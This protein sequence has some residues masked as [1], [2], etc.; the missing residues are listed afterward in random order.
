MILGEDLL[1]DALDVV[2]E[3]AG[4]N[5]AVMVLQIE[6]AAVETL[7]LV[8]SA[9]CVPEFEGEHAALDFVTT[10]CA[11]SDVMSLE[12]ARRGSVIV[13]I[14]LD[15]VLA[16]PEGR[17][18]VVDE[19]R[20]APDVDTAPLIDGVLW[21]GL[22]DPTKV[23]P[24]LSAL[25]GQGET[26][27]ARLAMKLTWCSYH[28][29]T[30]MQDPVGQ[31]PGHME[32]Q[33]FLRRA[34]EACRSNGQ[35]LAVVL[36]SPDDFTMVNHRHGRE[37]GDAVV[38]EIA[39]E[40]GGCVRLTD[41][42][43]RY[44]GA[45]FALVLPGTDMD[46][47]RAAIDKIRT[48]LGAHGYVDGT[49]SLTFSVGAGVAS[50][51]DL[52]RPGIATDILQRADGGLNTAK[53]S[54]GARALV[55]SLDEDDSGLPVDPLGAV[56]AADTEKDYRN[57][58]LL[59]E[60]V[61][62]VSASPEPEAMAGAFVDR[63]SMGFRPDRAALYALREGG[64]EP[65]ATNVRDDGHVDGRASGRA[66]H[67]ERRDSV[68]ISSAMEGGRVERGRDRKG[69]TRKD[70]G[71][72]AVRVAYAV[73]LVTGDRTVGCLYLDGREK[74]FNVDSSDVIFLNALAGQMAV[75]LDRAD[76]ASRWIREKDR[77]SRQL[78]EE[79]R[80]LRQALQHSK[81]VYQSA[82]MHAV[83]ETLRK[84]A[85][86][87]ATV[88]IIGESGTGK[89]M[90]AQALHEFSN[91][92]ETP[93][94]VFDCGAVAHSLLE[95]EL[96][97]H[98]KG[99]FTGA[100]NASEG[101]ISQADG[102]TLFLDEIGELPLSVQAKLLRFV[103][104]KEFAPVGS[105]QS[106]T[107]D[108]RIVAATNR[109]LQDEVGAGRFRAD[110]YYRL[111]VIAVQAIALRN[112][113]DDILPLAHYFL[114]KFA[115][116]YAGSARQFSQNAEQRLLH[117]HWPGN[118][119]ELQ[120]CVMRAVL[121]HEGEVIDADA[122]ELYPDSGASEA[123]PGAVPAEPAQWPPSV[124]PDRA[125]ASE[126]VAAHVSADPW[127]DLGAELPAQVENAL[128]QDSRR[129]APLGRWLTEDLV[130]AAHAAC[131]GVARRAAQLVG[132]PESTFRRQ[133][134][135]AQASGNGGGV[136]RDP[137]WASVTPVL[138]RIVDANGASNEDV[139]DRARLVLLG[140]VGEH[141]G[142]RPTVGAALMGVT[143]P[144]FKRWMQAGSRAA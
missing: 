33:V 128:Q 61:A 69:E 91:R 104:E 25:R 105:A 126:T 144:T 51:A 83:M 10:V 29:M 12:S 111:R 139:L 23:G 132:V 9:G 32:F 22:A 136:Y 57:M 60:T 15:S 5:D 100:E 81:M 45:V 89:E 11:T 76:L 34:I 102:G 78:R 30:V 1:L 14:A 93:F 54:G 52:A 68:L 99:A 17:R 88:L 140:V 19:R 87:D 110:L 3:A 84:V 121:T 16:R 35:A 129:P 92:R 36:A 112:R 64:L 37:H 74:S 72:R 95:A 13:R 118:V 38:A 59:W 63:V 124:Q 97:G 43:F 109:E 123:G 127:Q 115:A 137:A 47:C 119:R 41:G 122:I 96:F 107:V 114:E 2:Q 73:P 7:R 26:R 108:V 138:K 82:A 131:D 53:L 31:L 4:A 48:R 49:V 50:A 116:Q 56:F 141:Q 125:A 71:A 62:L 70:S 133:L 75:A 120:H 113:T 142:E 143:P 80:D 98:V 90:L 6:P 28:F 21:L 77:E 18:R 20:R 106:R 55:A 130:L 66:I 101:R 24:L 94:V 44:S 46:Q 86:S 67:L 135:K 8:G 65:L 39:A 79:L 40:I 27:V 42:V 58:L 85:P 134:D 103:Q 117:Y